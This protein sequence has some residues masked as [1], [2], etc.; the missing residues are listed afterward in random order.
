MTFYIKENDTSPSLAATLKDAAGT[1]IDLTAAT[2]RFHMRVSGAAAKVDA[3]A[4]V[5]SAANGTVR[6]DWVAADTDTVGTFEAE[7]EVTHSDSTIETFPNRGY[8]RVK[9]GGDI[10]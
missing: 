1:V 4:T 6:Y 9:I 5:V 10:A 3:A 7:F 2:V 8:I